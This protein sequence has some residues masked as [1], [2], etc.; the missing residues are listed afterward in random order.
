MK[1]FLLI[2]W[3]AA[4]NYYMPEAMKYTFELRKWAREE[5]MRLKLRS[6]HGLDTGRHDWR[7]RCE[8]DDASSAEQGLYHVAQ[9]LYDFLDGQQ[10]AIVDINLSKIK[11]QWTKDDSMYLLASKF[12]DAAIEFATRHER[13]VPPQQIREVL[14]ATLM[15]RIVLGPEGAQEG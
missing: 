7:R 3:E 2:E 11:D 15:K 6:D 1:R 13:T 12:A 10:V 8:L 9:L 14:K 5:G 4:V